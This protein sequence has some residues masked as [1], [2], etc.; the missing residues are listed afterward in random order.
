MYAIRS[1][2]ALERLLSGQAGPLP[3]DVSNDQGGSLPDGRESQGS[4][5]KSQEETVVEDFYDPWL[6]MKREIDDFP[7]ESELKL[8]CSYD[9]LVEIANADE[10]RNNFV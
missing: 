8:I 2:Y 9:L 4:A 10:L 7:A 5:F 3:I 6:K 1:Y